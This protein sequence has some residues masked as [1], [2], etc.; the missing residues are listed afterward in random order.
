MKKSNQFFKVVDNPKNPKIFIAFWVKGLILCKS[1][2]IKRSIT[3]PIV[4]NELMLK[5]LTAKTKA[6]FKVS[7]VGNFLKISHMK[8]IAFIVIL[9]NAK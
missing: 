7:N 5:K 1:G 9:P 4:N 8:I 2:W 3:G 6:M